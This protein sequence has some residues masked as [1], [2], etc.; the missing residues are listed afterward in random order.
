MYNQFLENIIIPLGDFFN[1]SSFKKDLI[2]WRNIDKSSIL[3]LEEL[4]KNNLSKI[5][6][7][8][9]NKTKVYN[10]INLVGNNPY[11]WL[12]E[13]PILTKEKLKTHTKELITENYNDLTKISSSG[14]SG[15]SSSVY[16]NSKDLS[17]LRAGLIHWWEWYG[18]KIGN[19]IIQTGISPNRG[20]LKRIKDYLF[21]TTYVSAFAH[22]EEQIITILNNIKNKKHYILVGY[23][24]SLNV[25]ANTAKKYNLNTQ[26]K[27]VISLGDKLFNHYRKNIQQQFKCK[28]FD[29]YG[30][31]EGFLIGAEFDLPYMYILSPQCYVE[32]LDD[33]NIPVP[34]GVMGNIVVTRLD[35][36][37]MPLIRYKIGD[38]GILLPKEKY[39]KNKKFNY[40]LLQQIIGRNTDVIKTKN[41]KT[42]IVHSFTGIFEYISEI[43]QFKV[44]QKNLDGILI[45]YIKAEGF[46]KNILQNITDKLQASIQD[47]SFKIKFKEVDSISPSNSGKPQIIKSYL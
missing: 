23:A 17:T 26:F 20:F 1:N 5:L 22:S 6:T 12:N 39:P 14:S 36:F 34:N 27:S 2:K 8:A 7:H 9:V 42:L 19:P 15:V 31:A 10:N 46:N 47:N 37:A 24:S 4:Q 44:I 29:T 38:L 11:N 18:Y 43:E 33:N 45:E 16:M 30:S 32:I 41:G 25:F 28:V 13:F 3:E 35:G 40:P 21:R